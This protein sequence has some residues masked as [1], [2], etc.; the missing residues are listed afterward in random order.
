MTAVVLATISLILLGV[1]MWLDNLRRRALSAPI[2]AQ[3]TTWLIILMSFKIVVATALVVAMLRIDNYLFAGIW[4]IA[5]LGCIL[6]LWWLLHDDNWFKRQFKKL[7]N[8]LKELGKRLSRIRV[9][10]SSPAPV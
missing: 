6:Q 10:P 5:T 1:A 9:S 8:G 3:L 7:K 2:K 4:S